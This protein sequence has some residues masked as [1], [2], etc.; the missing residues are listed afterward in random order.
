MSE[1]RIS[2]Q[3]SSAEAAAINQAVEDLTAKFAPFLIALN[4]EDKK[5]LA[6][7]ADRSLPFVEKAQQY[8]VSNPEFL[9]AYIDAA[10][11]KKDLEAFAFLKNIL[12]SLDQLVG[13]IEDTA[14]LCG[15][16]ANRAALLY[17]G[18]VAGAAKMNVPNAKTVY[19]DLSRRFES[20]KA[21]RS[22]IEKP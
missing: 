17:Y 16:E 1:N 8:G 18:S 15:S 21:R 22:K 13:N 10:E 2:I 14:A 20:Q 4:A 5:G 11:F 3:F 9:P 19:E 12:R 7:I 6:S